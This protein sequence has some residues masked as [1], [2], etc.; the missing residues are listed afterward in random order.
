VEYIQSFHYRLGPQE[1]K[2]VELF[3]ELLAKDQVSTSRPLRPVKAEKLSPPHGAKEGRVAGGDAK[4]VAEA[5]GHRPALP[6][7]EEI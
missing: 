7:G 5:R 1:L 4:G 6:I 2:A 3:R